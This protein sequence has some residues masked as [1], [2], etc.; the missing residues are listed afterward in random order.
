LRRPDPVAEAAHRDQERGEDE[1]VDRVDPLGGRSGKPRSR[2]IEGTATFTIVASTMIM[3]T[4]RLS[5]VRPSQRRRGLAPAVRV[6]VRHGS[7]SLSGA[8]FSRVIMVY[9]AM[10]DKTSVVARSAAPGAASD[11]TLETSRLLVEFLHAAYATRR[12]DTDVE[13]NGDGATKGDTWPSRHRIGRRVVPRGPGRDPY[14]SARRANGGAAGDRPGYLLRL[15]QS[16]RR[17]A[18][19]GGVRHPRAR[20][21]R[22]SG[23]AGEAESRQERR[24]RAGLPMA[25]RPRS[26]PRSS[27]W[28]L[29]NAQPCEYSCAG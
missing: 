8:T 17:R 5:M 3:A 27:P 22:S 25:W 14:L 24:S 21:R 7:I 19:E 1:G 20:C 13:G 23:R 4:P 9:S 15:G 11:T 26:P 16:R 18:G 6:R 2:A 10:V 28:P 29:P 12:L